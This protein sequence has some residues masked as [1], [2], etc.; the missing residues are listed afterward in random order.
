MWKLHNM[1]MFK[2]NKIDEYQLEITTYCNAA[3]PQ[4]PRNISGGSVN[5][6]M[7]LHHLSREVINQAFTTRLCNSLRQVFFCGSYGDPIV[8][9]DFLDILRDFRRKNPTLW[10]YI[11]TNGGVHNTEWWTELA[12]IINGYG[13][14]DFGIDGLEDTNHLYRRGV[15][16]ERAITNAKAYIDAGGKAQWNFIVFKHNEHQVDDARKLSEQIGFDNILFRGTGRFLNH[17]TLEEHNNW[18]VKPKKGNGYDLEVTTLDEYKNASMQRLGELKQE[19]PDIKEYFDTTPIKCDACVGNK[20]TITA[21]G[22][23]LP[24][25]FFEHN[26]YDAR[27]KDRSIAPGANNLHFVD[28]KNQV[29]E[30]VNQYRNEL[31]INNNSLQQVFESKF[32]PELV[33]SWSKDLNSGRIFEC[34]FTCGQ[35]LTKVWDQ[36]KK[37]KSTYRYYVTGNN[38]GL[39]QAIVNHFS[40][41]GSSRSTGLDI[42]TDIEKIVDASVHYDVFVNNAFDGPPDTEWACYAQVNLLQ[43][44][45]K[46]WRDI[47]K[48]GWIFNIGSVG[49]KTIV[50]PQPEFETYRVAKA[51]LAHASKQC[52]QAFKNN[53]VSFCTTLIT[54]DRLDTELSRSRDSWTGNGVNCEDVCRFIDYCVN[55]QPNTVCEEI[56]LYVNLDYNA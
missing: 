44:V 16:F 27:F 33:N 31:D 6:H 8:H 7:P 34:A 3:C 42:T 47:G 4:C 36:N 30:F 20:V 48:K 9:P 25:N 22:L 43:A 51:A 54:P 55:I 45:Y 52:T 38:R 19:Y 46:R 26:L 18:T 49:E 23:V 39:G 35:K 11:H 41:D 10:L 2:Y 56:I 13:K 40:A 28:G 32:W 37:I 14:I 15:T 12:H 50:A 53:H 5:P 1:P 21:E 24:C 17:E 29:S